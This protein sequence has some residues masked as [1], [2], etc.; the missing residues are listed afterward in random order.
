MESVQ[1]EELEVRTDG[2]MDRSFRPSWIDLLVDWI[3][4]LPGPS[5]LAFI[6][7][8][9]LLGLLAHLGF[10]A[11]GRQTPGSFSIN[12]FLNQLWIVTVLFAYNY[13]DRDAKRALDDFRPLMNLSD[14]DFSKSVQLFTNLPA[15]PVALL[16]VIGIPIALYL[17]PAFSRAEEFGANA[18]S[19]FLIIGPISMSL[20]LIFTYRIVRQLRLISQFYALASAID[21]YDL[22]PVYSLSAHTA[23]AGLALLLAVYLN[24]LAAPEVL[25]FASLTAVVGLLTLLALAAF[26]LPLRGINRRLVQVKRKLLQ[27]TQL[28]IKE[29]FTEIEE[30]YAASE[31]G[32]IS[33]LNSVVMAFQNQKTYIEEIPTWPWEASTLRGF[34]SL[35]LLP[36]FIWV[37][38]QI[39]GRFFGQ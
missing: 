17:D 22:G 16:T 29:A 36:I 25:E 7:L 10:W 8:F 31:L 33:T 13:L 30:S 18:L 32:E 2:A 28:R 38:Q 34:I 39:L 9:V 24:I 15:R 12:I 21:L 5:W 37:V 19:P 3:T 27:S 14:E 35:L 1:P 4:N 20:A 11:T 26:L 23:K 6:V